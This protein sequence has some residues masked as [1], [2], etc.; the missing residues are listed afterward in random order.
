MRAIPRGLSQGTFL[1]NSRIIIPLLSKIMPFD[2]SFRAAR[3]AHGTFPEP[4]FGPD[5]RVRHWGVPRFCTNEPNRPF[6]KLASFCKTPL[7][8]GSARFYTN[9][10]NGISAVP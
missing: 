3:D 8:Q 10:P 1:S 6:P 9:K 7:H 5:P 2:L 4:D